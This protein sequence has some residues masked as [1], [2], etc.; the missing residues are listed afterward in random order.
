MCF[1]CFVFFSEWTLVVWRFW[2]QLEKAPRHGVPDEMVRGCTSQ[3]FWYLLSC[4]QWTNRCVILSKCFLEKYFCSLRLGRTGK[5]SFSLV[6]RAVKTLYDMISV[7]C[8]FYFLKWQCAEFLLFWLYWVWF[9]LIWHLKPPL[10]ASTG[11]CKICN[12]VNFIRR[13]LRDFSSDI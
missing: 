4:V 3:C 6:W 5:S 12:K 9:S 8:G 7:F 10:L 11:S 13:M 2:Y 1:V